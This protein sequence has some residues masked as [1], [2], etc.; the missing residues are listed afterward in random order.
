MS[1]FWFEFGQHLGRKNPER[2]KWILVG[3]GLLWGVCQRDCQAAGRK[4]AR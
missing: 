3:Q 4:R 2:Y 1:R